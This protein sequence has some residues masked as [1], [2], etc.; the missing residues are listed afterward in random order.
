MRGR[1]GE[2]VQSFFYYTCKATRFSVVL[3]DRILNHLGPFLPAFARSQWIKYS[4]C[5][6]RPLFLFI[7]SSEKLLLSKFIIY[8]D[9]LRMICK[10]GI[11]D[12][13][14]SAQNIFQEN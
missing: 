2:L 1:F 7:S 10:K 6:Q 9:V 4:E 3:L 11:Q 13:E 14:I 5:K 8:I 12:L